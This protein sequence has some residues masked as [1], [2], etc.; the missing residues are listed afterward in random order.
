MKAILWSALWLLPCTGQAAD[1]GAFDFVHAVRLLHGEINDLLRAYQQAENETGLLR[2][3][4]VLGR[5]PGIAKMCQNIFHRVQ[6]RKTVS[7]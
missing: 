4:R 5:Y 3:G 1:C 2:L 7:A 6:E